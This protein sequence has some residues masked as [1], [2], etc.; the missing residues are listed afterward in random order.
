M[1]YRLAAPNMLAVIIISIVTFSEAWYVGKVNTVA[2]AGLAIVFPFQT[3]MGMMGN[4]GMGNGTASALSRSIGKN[5]FKRA[6]SVIWHSALI[7]LFISLVY[8]IALGIFSRSI[9]NLFGASEEVTDQAVLYARIFFGLAPFIWLY[10]W[11]KSVLRGLGAIQIMARLDIVASVIQLVLSG[12]LTL[13]WFFL[14]SL[15]LVGPAIAAVLCQGFAGVAM[16]ILFVS[17]KFEISLKIIPLDF[18]VTKDILKVGGMGV[19]LAFNI[20]LTI[21]LTTRFVADFGTEAIA[22]YGVCGRLEQM[23]IPLAFGVGGVLVVIV[24]TNFGASQY[25]RAR[26]SARFGAL[27]IALVATLIGVILALFPSLWIDLFI[28]ELGAFAI[29]SVYLRIVGPVF[30]LFAGGQTLS[31][32]SY[33][34]GSMIIPVFGGVYRVLITSIFGLSVSYF[35]LDISFL[36]WGVTIGMVGWAIILSLNMISKVWNPEKTID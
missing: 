36:F 20:A 9:F 30:G 12:A 13:G 34:T 19:L 10:F 23:L 16:L 14:P 6:H 17:G 32:A 31:F 8:L 21:M 26:K 27:I 24:G 4:G 35:S 2:L 15:G 29:G 5:D 28:K 1:L 11:M 18:D 25:E 3:L 7:N 33:G 22:G